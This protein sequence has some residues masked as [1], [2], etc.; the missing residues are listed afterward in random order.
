LPKV[1]SLANIEKKIEF[2]PYGFAEDG[3]VL[4]ERAL[5]VCKTLE[6]YLQVTKDF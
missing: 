6:K 2:A 1:P 4:P 5:C 3:S